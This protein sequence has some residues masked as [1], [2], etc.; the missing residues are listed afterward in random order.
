MFFWRTGGVW[1]L[2][3]LGLLLF[4]TG[5]QVVPGREWVQLAWPVGVYYAAIGAAGAIAGFLG[6]QRRIVASV[7]GALAG[8]ASL[9]LIGFAYQHL[10]QALPDRIVGVIGLVALVVGLIPGVLAYEL[11]DRFLPPPS[12]D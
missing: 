11:C 6:G 1:G 12:D 9:G 10:P 5:Y 8:I 2:V 4:F 7:C 3:A